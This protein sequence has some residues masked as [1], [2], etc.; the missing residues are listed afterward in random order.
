MRE[1]TYGKADCACVYSSHNCL[2][3]AMR[4]KQTACMQASSH[5]LLV[6]DS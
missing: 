6:I 3:V 5:I 1:D 2:M 4:Q